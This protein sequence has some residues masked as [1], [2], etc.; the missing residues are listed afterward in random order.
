MNA[1]LQ[2]N[3]S[4]QHVETKKKNFLVTKTDE[5]GH[6]AVTE[7]TAPP[8]DRQCQKL[9]AQMQIHEYS[10]NNDVKK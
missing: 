7:P 8:T 6:F 4:W 9:A 2:S 5:K 1:S 3:K 10:Y